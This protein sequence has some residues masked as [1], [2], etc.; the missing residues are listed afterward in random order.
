MMLENMKKLKEQAERTNN[1][2]DEIND[3]RRKKLA[4]QYSEITKVNL[5]TSQKVVLSYFW[6]IKA[7][8]VISEVSTDVILYGMKSKEKDYKYLGLENKLAKILTDLE[9][10]KLIKNFDITQSSNQV[11]KLTELGIEEVNSINPRYSALQL[12]WRDFLK[13]K[14]SI[15]ITSISFISAIVGLYAFVIS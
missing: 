13:N 9:M 4:K 2:L 6:H 7:Q 5:S 15:G 1:T 12:E 10:L 8:T 3:E 11:I 14:V